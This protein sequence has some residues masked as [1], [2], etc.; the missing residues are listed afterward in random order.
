[1]QA[2]VQSGNRPYFVIELDLVPT[3]LGTCLHD[4]VDDWSDTWQ[5]EATSDWCWILRTT[6]LSSLDSLE[7]S[8]PTWGRGAGY[9]E[10]ISREL[11]GKQSRKKCG[12]G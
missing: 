1:M 11:L 9:K 5:S 12:Q 3:C 6:L 8:G 4:E 10:G 2:T 7:K